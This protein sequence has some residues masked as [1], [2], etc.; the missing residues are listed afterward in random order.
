MNAKEFPVHAATGLGIQSRER[1]VHQQNLRLADEA[2]TERHPAA[3]PAGKLMRIGLLEAAEPDKIE[4]RTGAP[5]S[6]RRRHGASLERERDVLD[7]HPPRQQAIILE[8]VA[9]ATPVNRGIGPLPHHDDPAGVG[10]DEA[11]SHVEQR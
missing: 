3:H 5:Q 2:A 1:L 7:R 8:H 9:D 4:H 6:L 10:K 11:R